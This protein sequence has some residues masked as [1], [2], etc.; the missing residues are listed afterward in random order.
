MVIH[1]WSV[2]YNHPSTTLIR[3]D[4]LIVIYLWGLRVQAD[5]DRPN[6]TTGL[7]LRRGCIRTI[8]HWRSKKIVEGSSTMSFAIKWYIVYSFNGIS[9]SSEDKFPSARTQVRR[10]TIGWW[11]LEGW[12]RD[13]AGR[14]RKMTR[15]L[16]SESEW[17]SRF[18][19]QWM[20]VQRRKG[21][22]N[23]INWS[24]YPRDAW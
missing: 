12:R 11:V 23:S 17:V 21:G 18:F 19:E 14:T 8:L 6:R 16:C 2:K 24:G 9:R 20:M 13:T 5:V 15:F 22:T 10:N 3:W 7:S 1:L 4:T